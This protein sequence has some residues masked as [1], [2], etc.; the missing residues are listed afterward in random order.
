VENPHL[1]VGLGNPG[2]EYARTRHNCGFMA[3]EEFAARRGSVWKVERKFQ[4]RLARAELGGSQL[5]LAEPQ[6]Y[7]NLSGQAV[8]AIAAYFKVTPA[9]VLVVVDDADLPLGALRMR[10]EGSAGGHHG[11]ESI[12]A[13]LGT[14]QYA[15][16]RIGI[17]R[18]SE[19]LREITDYVLGRFEASEAGLLKQ[20]LERACDQLEAWVMQG[21]AK[22][23]NEFNGVINPPLV[24]ES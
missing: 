8:Q 2:T 3:V 21:P 16:Q 10:P 19:G 9:R 1:I 4:A 20:V 17:G 5:V 18:R 15:R 11:L 12:E 23:M 24:M 14:R 22:A 7:M 13:H 6:T